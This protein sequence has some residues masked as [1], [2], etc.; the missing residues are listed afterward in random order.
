MVAPVGVG[1]MR[2]AIFEGNIKK[3]GGIVVRQPLQEG[4]LVD[5]L[6]A[7][8]ALEHKPEQLAK[9]M[10]LWETCG[11]RKR[12][13]LK[14]LHWM[15]DMLASKSWLKNDGE[16]Q[17]HVFC[18]RRDGLGN[19][20]ESGA[21]CSPPNAAKRVLSSVTTADTQS[22]KRHSSYAA[23]SGP[24]GGDA[25]SCEEQAERGEKKEEGGEGVSSEPPLPAVPRYEA[26]SKRPPPQMSGMGGFEMAL[27]R[28]V[29]EPHKHDKV[30]LLPPFLSAPLTLNPKP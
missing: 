10:E 11:G 18:L 27:V 30:L 7:E 3:Y 20:T 17:N 13:E 16:K 24:S 28:I 25:D 15:E 12:C 29:D 23:A 4:V 1:G 14:T 19:S 2:A 22:P 8:K 9:L 6:L 21:A 5:Y 26:N